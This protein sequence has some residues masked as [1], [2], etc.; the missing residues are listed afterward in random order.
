MSNPENKDPVVKRNSKGQIMPGSSGNPGGRPK[1]CREAREYLTKGDTIKE[2]CIRLIKL[3]D[4][5]DEKVALQAI[6]EY[7]DR[8]VG[9][10]GLMVDHEEENAPVTE[11]AV[12]SI[13]AD[14]VSKRDAKSQESP[15]V[16]TE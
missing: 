3:I 13:I 15:P 14:L 16:T 5:K 8:V 10:P 7:F 4:S 6:K 2:V 9:R 11:D 12:R 1:A